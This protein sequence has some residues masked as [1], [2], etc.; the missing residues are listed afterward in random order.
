MT[1]LR[2]FHALTAVTV[3]L[4][5]LV[6]GAQPARAQTAATVTGT[7]SDTSGGALPGVRL[8][9]QQ[10]ATGL[11]RTLV[12]GPD[13]RFVFAGVPVGEY[14]LRAELMGFRPLVRQGLVLTVGQTASVPLEMAVGGIEQAVTVLGDGALVNTA[15]SELSFLVGEQAIESLPLNGRNYTDLAL[16]AAR[17][18]AV[19]F[20]RWR[21]G[22]RA[23]PGHERQRAGLSLQR[24]SARWHAAERLHER[25]RG[26]R[27]R[28]RARHGVDPGVPRR[29]QRLQRGVRP[30]LRRPDQ[31]A[32]QVGH[33]HRPRQ[34]LRV[35]PQRRARREELLRRRRQARVRTQSVRRG[36]RRPAAPEPALLLRRLRRPA[37]EPR[38]DDLELRARR[39]RA[40]RACCPTA[41]SRSAMS[42]VRISM[43][44]RGRT[45][46]RSAAASPRTPLRSIRN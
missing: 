41:R 16:L 19:P 44:F 14:A 18:A 1:S 23:R 12:S 46:R 26:E 39:Q 25:A 17:R 42:S 33:Q 28:H 38:Q 24:V 3:G 30:Q 20:A 2:L 27:R 4:A 7:V 37:R 21:V 29:D 5:L 15:T 10:M 8:T 32:H 31:R 43:P 11:V 40:S 13:G 22:R 9:L 35:P 45:A 34:R 36:A 6:A